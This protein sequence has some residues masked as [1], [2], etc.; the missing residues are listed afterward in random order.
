MMYIINLSQKQQCSSC[1]NKNF[2]WRG[3][4]EIYTKC[5]AVMGKKTIPK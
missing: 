2:V 1:G 4:W 5:G 3:I